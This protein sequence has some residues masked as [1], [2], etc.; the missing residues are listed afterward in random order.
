MD[1]SGLSGS[2]L[3]ARSEAVGRHLSLHP[4]HVNLFSTPSRVILTGFAVGLLTAA[5][6]FLVGRI[7]PSNPPGPTPSEQ[8]ADSLKAT[9]PAERALIDSSNE[10]IAA[11]APS[12]AK[13]EADA[14]AS[15]AS[16]AKY[17]HIADSLAVVAASSA[18]SVT[19]WHDAYVNRSAEAASLRTVVASDAITITNLKA[20]TA[21]LRFQLVTVNKRLKTTEDVN[22]GLRKD[23]EQARQCK[24]VGFIN[25]PSRIQT[26]AMTAATYFAVDL[27]RSKRP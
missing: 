23:L 2:S 5:G 9:K 16:A 6:W 7:F 24:I 4:T 13:A 18:D 12:S 1:L 17:Q 11:R 10:H 25:C 15:K 20:D 14:K 3:S 26:A 8:T 27:Y 22:K 21:D 19:A